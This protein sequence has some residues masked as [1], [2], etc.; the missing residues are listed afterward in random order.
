MSTMESVASYGIHAAQE[1]VRQGSG[2]LEGA[3]N[4][5]FAG[6]RA[7]LEAEGFDAAEEDRGRQYHD[8]A[9]TTL[10]GAQGARGARTASTEAQTQAQAELADE[11]GRRVKKTRAKLQEKE[12]DRPLLSALNDAIRASS[13]SHA[14]IGAR[15]TTFLEVIRQPLQRPGDAAPVTIKQVA[16]ITDALEKPLADKLA[17]YQASGY[18]QDG[19][20]GESQRLTGEKEHTIALLDR[21]LAKWQHIAKADFTDDELTAFG[22][23]I[24]RVKSLRRQSRTPK[25]PA[26]KKPESK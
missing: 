1:I 11:F 14:A 25:S 15:V 21:W 12:A 10:A 2:F 9:S 19:K 13:R 23:P 4:P 16:G 6:A 7:K 26:E 22:I 5:E 20:T 18:S 8:D 24:N 17:A 3:R